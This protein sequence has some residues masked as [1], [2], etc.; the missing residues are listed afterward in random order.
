LKGRSPSQTA[1]NYRM[2][3]KY[4]KME[5]LDKLNELLHYIKGVEPFSKIFAE[6]TKYRKQWCPFQH[7]DGFNLDCYNTNPSVQ[8]VID[9]TEKYLICCKYLD[10]NKYSLDSMTDTLQKL[11]IP[12]KM[13]GYDDFQLLIDDL[14]GQ[15][16]FAEQD[17]CDKLSRLECTECIRLDE[18]LVCFQNYCF[19]AAIVMAVSAVEYRIA[20]MI[21]RSD[22][23]LY[24]KHFQGAT[25]GQLIK[26]FQDDEYKDEKFQKI[27][28]L[29]P[30]KH[31]PLI[32]LLNNY[33]V[34]A[35]H[36]TDQKVTPQIAEAIIHLAFSFLTDVQTC[37]YDP[38]EM[39][40]SES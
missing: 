14:K 32:S 38:E 30:I 3:V 12:E 7:D 13:S 31:K 34:F 20:E 28:E 33:R 39:V 1:I 26:V 19:Y 2:G 37:P 22:Q 8:A 6:L 23:E 40:C 29:M 35:A 18:T 24:L 9:W 5:D 16:K 17:I 10:I 4:L 25:L 15:I 36:P 27:K 21:R 11:K